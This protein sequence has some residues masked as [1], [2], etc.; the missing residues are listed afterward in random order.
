MIF[1][2]LVLNDEANSFYFVDRK[3]Y[4]MLID[5]NIRQIKQLI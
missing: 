4:T 3:N 1:F 2:L 5:S